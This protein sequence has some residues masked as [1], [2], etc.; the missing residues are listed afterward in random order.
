MRSLGFFRRIRFCTKDPHYK[1][2]PIKSIYLYFKVNIKPFESLYLAA[3]RPKDARARARSGKGRHERSLQDI[4]KDIDTIWRE[5]Q[6]LDREWEGKSDSRPPSAPAPLWEQELVRPSWRDSH[7]AP[8]PHTASQPNISKQGTGRHTIWDPPRQP[9]PP[10]PLSSSLSESRP[11]NFP[12]RSATH[13][14]FLPR[15]Q[16]TRPGTITPAYTSTC[17]LNR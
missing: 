17:S 3:C 7:H 13:F 2:L 4:D 15:N 9:A 5:L 6:Q 16:E 14:S 8:R 12:P 10:A 11:S 1:R